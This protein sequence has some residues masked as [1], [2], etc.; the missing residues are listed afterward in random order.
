MRNGLLRQQVKS[1]NMIFAKSGI[2]L[3]R[4]KGMKMKIPDIPENNCCNHTH[5]DVNLVILQVV[6]AV[7][8]YIIY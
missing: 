2:G 7:S 5:N 1:H 6:L 4:T 3:T 8:S